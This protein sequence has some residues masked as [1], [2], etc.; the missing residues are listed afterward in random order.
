[1]LRYVYKLFP[2]L[3]LCCVKTFF[4]FPKLILFVLD[5]KITL[6]SMYYSVIY[7]CLSVFQPVYLV[8]Y[9]SISLFYDTV[10]LRSTFVV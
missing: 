1:M 8:V 9:L 5:A 6:V 7:V 3:K 2:L 10:F 4:A